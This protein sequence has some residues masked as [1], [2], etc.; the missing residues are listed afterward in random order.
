MSKLIDLTG[1]HMGKLKVLEKATSTNG[2]TQWMCLCDCGKTTIVRS[3]KLRNK[4]TISCGCYGKNKLGK[5]THKG[6]P[7][8]IDNEIAVFKTSCGKEFFA[9]AEDAERV[10]NIS[11]FMNKNGYLHGW[12]P[13]SRKYV[14]LHRYILRL[15]RK[16]CV[17]HVDRNPRNNRKANLRLCTQNENAKNVSKSS[18]NTS[19]FTG[20]YREKKTG[21]WFARI[22][23]EKRVISLG[24]YSSFGEAVMKRYEAEK[25]YFGEYSPHTWQ[26]VQAAISN[27]TA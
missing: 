22:T 23:N 1:Q 24:T 13:E 15:D 10:G 6:T 27:H 18:R 16:A 17:D 3:Q 8:Y 9:D 26:D 7:Y 21:K 14:M 19:G 2:Q 5:M 4:S 12:D 20:V 25:L 11:W